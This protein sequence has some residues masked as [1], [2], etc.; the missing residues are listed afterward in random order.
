MKSKKVLIPKVTTPP[1]KKDRPSHIGRAELIHKLH[2]AG[3][4]LEE[5]VTLAKKAGYTDT[6]PGS[7]RKTITGSVSGHITKATAPAKAPPAKGAKEQIAEGKAKL[8]KLP[9]AKKS[10][11]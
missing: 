2:A 1:V 6:S 9:P 10:Q 3:K 4:S 11:K 7:V 5:M 8:S